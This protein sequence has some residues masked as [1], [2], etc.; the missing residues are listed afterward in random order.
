VEKT[1]RPWKFEFCRDMSLDL[2]VLIKTAAK[3]YLAYKV[4]GILKT[5][6]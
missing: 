3:G 4:Y 6:T 5:E 1:G 2:G